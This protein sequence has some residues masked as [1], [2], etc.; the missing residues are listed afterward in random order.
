MDFTAVE[1]EYTRRM[2]ALINGWDVPSVNLL[3]AVDDGTGKWAR[4]FWWD[5][6]HP[7]ASGHAELATTFV[8]SLF[9]AL[10]RGIPRPARPAAA[11]YARLTGGAALAFAPDAPMHPYA[12]GFTV[13]TTGDGAIARVAGRTL[14]AQTG[15]KTITRPGQEPQT[16]ESTTLNPDALASAAVTV[17]RGVWAYESTAGTTVASSV[18]ADGRWHDILVSHYTARGETLFFVDGILAGRAPERLAPESFVIGGPS[19]ER[20]MDLKDVLIYRSAL[21]AGEAAALH[22]GKLLQASLEV[23]APLADTR[24]VKKQPLENRAQSFAILTLE[25]GQLSHIAR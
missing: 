18:P 2:N 6:L 17:R 20:R 24:A 9:D 19:T 14:A 4:G 21:N 8:P 1:Y 16:I 12:L 10:E 22:S 11:G 15:S 5:S 3:G 25:S 7:N 13:R 23:Y